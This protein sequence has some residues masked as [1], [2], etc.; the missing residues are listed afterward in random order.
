[1]A[2]AV[3]TNNRLGFGV[4][5]SPWPEDYEITG[6]A[7]K[8]RGKRMDEMIEVIRGLTTGD[9]FEFHGEFYDIP[10]IKMCPAPSAPVPILIGGHSEAAL[11]RAARV[12][13]GWMH[14]G[15]DT[16]ELARM[17]ARLNELRAQYGREREPFEIHVISLDA[18]NV[19]GI[20]QL[21]DLGVTDAI[22][23]FRDAYGKAQDT[24]TLEDKVRNL[25]L[26]A[27]HVMS[28]A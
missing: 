1:M 20:Q 23:G 13:D 12:G 28:K 18:F 4:G 11:K 24:E 9:Y 19:D 16:D 27:E 17:I 10:S 6:Q 21:E 26:F 3:L 2:T 8:R 14:A 5:L 7:W 15:G 22:V 25:E